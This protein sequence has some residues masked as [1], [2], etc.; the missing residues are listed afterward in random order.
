M[1]KLLKVVV[2]H[3]IIKL[4]EQSWSYR[5]IAR[6]LDVHRETVAR[7]DRLRQSAG[8]KPANDPRVPWFGT[9]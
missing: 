5:R 4:L 7:Y 1:A 6:E 9:A 8:S 2:I 3:A